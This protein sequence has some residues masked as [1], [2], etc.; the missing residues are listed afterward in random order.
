MLFSELYSQEFENHYSLKLKFNPSDYWWSTYNNYGQENSKTNFNYNGNYKKN[1]AQYYFSV[2]ISEDRI[3]MGESFLQ[4]KI[5][6]KTYIK[7]G[8]YYRDFSTY[9]NDQL[10]SGSLLV[11]NNAE[12][13]PKVGFLSSYNLK[14]NKNFNFNYGVA[15]AIFEKNNFYKKA[16]MLHEK[17]IYLQHSKKNIEW[18]IGLVHEA[19]WGGSVIGGRMPGNQPST[20]KDFFKIIISADG[21]DE[22]GSHPNALGNHLGIWDFNYKIS[23]DSKIINLYYQHFFEDTSGLRF[24]NRFDGLWGVELTNYIKDSTILIEYINTLNQNIDPPYID[25]AYY[26]HGIYQMGW[27]YKGYT[28]GNPFINH[29]EAVPIEVVHIAFDKEKNDKF[30]G[31]KTSKITS[32][33]KPIDFS[34][35]FIKNF[36]EKYYIG[37]AINGNKDKSGFNFTFSTNQ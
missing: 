20:I 4:Y 14:K 2:F 32:S 9:L 10:S 13:M 3:N 36:S 6:D 16:P 11:S 37:I 29:L 30:Y 12:S 33:N 31:F 7:A 23:K 28:I 22:G 25:D 19:M 26:N 34:V 8:K 21:P 35:F 17:F 15:H 1:N 24:A 5:F 27:S 18:S